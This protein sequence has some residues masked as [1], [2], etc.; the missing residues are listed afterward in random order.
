LKIGV[1]LS[2]GMR[3]PASDDPRD[4]EAAERAADFY[5]RW[6]FDGIFR[7]KYPERITGGY[8]ELMPEIREGDMAVVST[9]VDWLGIN[10][11]S[12]GIM[13]H[14]EGAGFLKAKGVKP[15]KAEFTDF[16]WEVYPEGIYRVLKWASESYGHPDIYITENGASYGEGPDESGRVRDDRRVSFLRRYFEA[17]RRAVSE[18]VKLKGYFVWSIMDNFEWGEGFSQRFGIVHVDYATQKRTPKDS[19]LWYRGVIASNG[20]DL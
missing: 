2:I 11:Y 8:P 12:R 6:Y 13:A 10:N 5:E 1:A 18:G 14:D 15:G 19:A 20:A 3:D 4:R 16:N 17:A 7:G 9:P